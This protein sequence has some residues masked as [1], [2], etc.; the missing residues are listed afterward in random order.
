ML[1]AL[2]AAALALLHAAPPPGARVVLPASGTVVDGLPSSARWVAEGTVI[3]GERD[4]LAVDRL[5]AS[6]ERGE[7]LLTIE[8]RRAPCPPTPVGTTS[9][10]PTLG[11]AALREPLPDRRAVRS[12]KAPNLDLELRFPYGVEV[13]NESLLAE[14]DRWEAAVAA[15]HAAFGATRVDLP[16]AL[17]SKHLLAYEPAP[18]S[19][20]LVLTSDLTLERP[21]DGLT[22][23]VRRLGGH[24]V[25][26]LAAPTGAG[27]AIQLL[28]FKRATCEQA[29]DAAVRHLASPVG[30]VPRAPPGW[31]VARAVGAEGVALCA[32]GPSGGLVAIGTARVVRD[33]WLPVAGPLLALLATARPR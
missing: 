4:V 32:V 9:P 29:L 2:V 31:Q 33:A 5:L 7:R 8:V 14:A 28:P 11:Y 10:W 13:D 6:D 19:A 18:A 17:T 16:G 27:L 26:V 1:P 23:L 25:L 24:A 21:A 20:P 12:C 3:I 30:T 15:L 22:W